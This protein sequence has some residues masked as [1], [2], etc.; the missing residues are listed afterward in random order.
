MAIFALLLPALGFLSGSLMFSF[1]LSKLKGKDLRKIGDGNPGAV[2]AFRAT[3]F[4]LGSLGLILDFLKGA[5]PV[6]IGYWHFHLTGIPLAALII[7]PVL[8][9]IF[10][11]WLGLRG[12]KGIATTFGVWSGVTLWQV[13]CF[14]GATLIFT[15]FVLGIRRDSVCVLITLVALIGFVILFYRSL[16]LTIAAV[17]NSITVGYRHLPDL[18]RR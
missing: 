10:S 4:W 8:G 7:T 2:N 15:R 16:P 12:G 14:L 18:A 11:P 3:G 13:P 6:A 17:L 1:W 9:H 5:V